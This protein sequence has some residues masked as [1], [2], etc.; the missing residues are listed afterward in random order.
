MK[1]NGLRL[2]IKAALIIT[3]IFTGCKKDEEETS[4][5]LKVPENFTTI[6]AAI[7]AAST[8][9]VIIVSPGTYR[10]NINFLG[11]MITVQSTQPTN[12]DTVLATIIDGNNQGRT[13]TFESGEPEG[14]LLWGFTITGGAAGTSADGGGIIATNNSFP[15]IKECVIKNNTARYGAGALATQQSEPIFTKN[16]FEE[17][18]STGRRGGAIYVMNQSAPVIRENT[19][20]HHTDM[21]AVIHVGGSNAGQSA[22]AEIKDNYIAFNST[23][24]G[25]GAIKVTASSQATIDNNTIIHN[26]GSGDNTGGAIT[27]SHSSS[28]EI[29]HN[30]IEYNVAGYAGAVIIYRESEAIINGNLIVNNTA[31][32]GQGGGILLTYYGTANISNNIISNNVAKSHSRGGGGIAVY[33]W[34]QETHAN[35]T[36]NE[37]TNNQAHRRGGGIY[38]SGTQTTAV[39]SNNNI[40]DNTATPETQANGGGIY[41]GQIKYANIF[42]NDINNNFSQWRG[43]GI[44]IHTH[45]T[46]NDQNGNP[47][48]RMNYP[49][50][51]ETHN[52]YTNNQHVDDTQ[53]GAHVFFD[54]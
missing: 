41:V 22:V 23:T 25:S 28:V 48:A 32:T 29:T 49:P 26:T 20:Q 46:F 30:T 10:E 53:M 24:Y 45:G 27:V 14:T 37:I 36:D 6:Q 44:F 33:S 54:N 19:F 38:L 12:M 9:D 31:E 40:S 52:S 8:G 7:D 3:V 11:K 43:G 42:N 50:T 21:D 4:G 47:L 13:V 1:A 2:F 16:V 15:E 35:I 5:K 51:P 17:N 39:I 18:V 34:G